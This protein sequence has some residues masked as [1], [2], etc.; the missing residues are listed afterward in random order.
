MPALVALLG[1]AYLTL[2]LSV[3]AALLLWL[4]LRRPE[5]FAFVRT[6]LL[7]ASALALVGFV[8]FPTAPPRL[9]GLGITDTV[10]GGQ[11]DL[12]HGLVSS[13][14]NSYAA[15]PSLHMGYALIVGGALISCGRHRIVRIVGATYPLLVLPM[16]VATGQHF[17]F[18][19]AAGATVVAVAAVLSALVT[20]RRRLVGAA[21]S[22]TPGSGTVLAAARGSRRVSDDSAGFVRAARRATAG[23]H[24]VLTR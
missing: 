18:D 6:T 23:D 19:A 17:L 7:L 3:T 4:H 13:I 11:V 9:A 2:H 8:V 20:Q 12:N 5:N 16:I 10:S 15:V 1:F 22:W 24:P 14:Y 21:S